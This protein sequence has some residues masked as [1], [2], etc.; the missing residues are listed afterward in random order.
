MKL[1][2][3]KNDIVEVITG[4]DKGI[5]GRVLEVYPKTMKVLVEGVN[6]RKKHERPNPQNQKGG[7]R[8]KEMPVHYSNVLLVDSDKNP[9]R[10]GIRREENGEPKRYAKTNGK[11]LL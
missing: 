2:I 4:N 10:T 1:K 5:Q 7:I 9:T 3:K 8:E 6:I 11:D